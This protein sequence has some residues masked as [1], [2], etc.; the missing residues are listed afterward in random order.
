MTVSN[1][2]HVSWRA[3]EMSVLGYRK[4]SYTQ[5]C[6]INLQSPEYRK[7]IDVFVNNSF[8]GKLFK[9]PSQKISNW[10]YKHLLQ[11]AHILY[12]AAE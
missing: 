10:N 9:I 3:P 8:Q 2:N 4:D 5:L 1:L 12:V 7:K 11:K 6:S